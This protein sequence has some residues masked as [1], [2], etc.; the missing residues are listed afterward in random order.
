MRADILLGLDR[1]HRNGSNRASVDESVDLENDGGEGP[2]AERN[3]ASVVSEAGRYL[4]IHDTYGML[5]ASF[6]P[7]PGSRY[8]TF[9]SKITTYWQRHRSANEGSRLPPRHRLSD[10]RPMLIQRI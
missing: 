3:E 6:Q 7:I 5:R 4:T 1:D 8:G 9:C 10:V 2:S